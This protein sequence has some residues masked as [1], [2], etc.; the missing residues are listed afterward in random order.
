MQ[1]AN[2]A[3]NVTAGGDIELVSVVSQTDGDANDVVISSLN[4][5]ITAGSIITGTLGDVALNAALGSVSLNN[6]IVA[7]ELNVFTSHLIVDYSNT[8]PFPAGGFVFTGSG[9]L[10]DDTL[11][12]DNGMVSSVIYRY[13]DSVT[14]EFEADGEVI[15][16][17]DI[18]HIEDNLIAD[19]R[20]FDTS[21]GA[22]HL[23]LEDNGVTEDTI[24]RFTNN[25]IGFS[26]DFRIA[27]VIV[28][29]R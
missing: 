9:G 3:I 25:D 6:Q 28:A 4:G 16:H 23:T 1:S 19:N 21:D 22:D 20:T 29:A 13:I 11:T 7:D 8:I 14:G 17:I 2:G 24:S 27:S 18:E 26:I 10:G 12:V 5:S 15:R